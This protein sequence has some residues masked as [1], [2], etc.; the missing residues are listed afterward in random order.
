MFV[1]FGGTQQNIFRRDFALE[2]NKTFTLEL[3]HI[4]INASSRASTV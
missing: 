4:E 1:P 2:M 3:R